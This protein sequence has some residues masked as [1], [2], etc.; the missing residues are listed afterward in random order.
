[1]GSVEVCV[2]DV[3]QSKVVGHEIKRYYTDALIVPDV[4]GVECSPAIAF[5]SLLHI[6]FPLA[7]K[8]YL[9]RLP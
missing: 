3:G 8:G 2:L 5:A 1:M 4:V 6:Y 7:G 9:D